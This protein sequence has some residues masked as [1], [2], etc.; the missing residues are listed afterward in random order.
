MNEYR[1]RVL[2]PSATRKYDGHIN[3]YVKILDM[4]GLKLSALNQIKRTWVLEF[5]DLGGEIRRDVWHALV[6]EV[7]SLYK[8]I[9]EFGPKDGDMTL[10][11]IE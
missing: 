2:L 3:T 8:F 10:S 9:Q 6:S 1:D 7:I 5:V 11:G 4:T